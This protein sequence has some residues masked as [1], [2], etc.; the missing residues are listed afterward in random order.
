ME[1]KSKK[2]KMTINYQEI[3]ENKFF[4]QIYQTLKK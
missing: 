2:K 1:K 3:Q 4:I